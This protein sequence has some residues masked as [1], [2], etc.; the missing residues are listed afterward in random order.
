MDI[1]KKKFKNVLLK[2]ENIEI[3]Y[4]SPTNQYWGISTEGVKKVIDRK[5]FEDFLKKKK[6][7]SLNLEIKKNSNFKKKNKLIR[8]PNLPSEI[9]E[10][11]VKFCFNKLFN[12]D[13]E[14]NIGADLW[15]KKN[16][17][18]VKGFVLNSAPISF[19]PALDFK[20]IFFL[21]AEDIINGNF[22]LYRV[23]IDSK[24]FKNLKVNLKFK[25]KD[26]EYI[27]I[28]PKPRPR[29]GFKWLL[30]QLREQKIDVDFY[31]VTVDIEKETISVNKLFFP[32]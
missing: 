32:I 15:K 18:E 27:T 2:F 1:K 24:K 20:S 8:N 4:I 3:I 29:R 5:N 9:S 22:I 13:M 21:N 25:F 14:W 16:K 10:N 17:Y 30:Q 23:K 19:S 28:K 12:I 6:I 26:L 11:L 31:L 7:I